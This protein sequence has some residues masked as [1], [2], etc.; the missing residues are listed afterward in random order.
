GRIMGTKLPKDTYPA[1]AS[2]VDFQCFG[3]PATRDGDFE[4]VK[5]CDLGCFTQD[6]KDSN[7]YY[8]A[9]VVQPKKSH[10]WFA[11]FEWGRC[12][13]A[14]P[15]CRTARARVAP[16]VRGRASRVHARQRGRCQPA[17]P[18]RPCRGPRSARRGPETT[19]KCP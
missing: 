6:G 1:Q 13:A 4:S 10:K 14:R 15:Q 18:G 19:H 11:Y 7:K 2:G 12:R 8:H 17:P 5:L 3:P 16:R 9:A